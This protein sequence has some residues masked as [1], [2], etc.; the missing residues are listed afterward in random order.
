M[1]DSDLQKGLKVAKQ[2]ITDYNSPAAKIVEALEIIEPIRVSNKFAAE[3]F[4]LASK[5]PNTPI[6]TIV[7][8][9]QSDREIILLDRN[10]AIDLLLAEAPDLPLKIINY[11][12]RNLNDYFNKKYLRGKRTL[13]DWFLK[14]LIGLPKA[15]EKI[16]LLPSTTTN[17]LEIIYDR[18]KNS[19]NLKLIH[20][21]CNN[22]NA[23]PKILS[24]ILDR[25]QIQSCQSFKAIANHPN[26]PQE[27][28]TKLCDDW[29]LEVVTAA[30]SNPNLPLTTLHQKA[31]FSH[32]SIAA[33][34]R[35]L[36]FNQKLTKATK[37]KSYLLK[38]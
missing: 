17:W 13:P 24:D 36:L 26:T 14:P 8:I 1:L 34:A 6:D 25:P 28:L 20:Y 32:P 10:P 35:S 18:Y 23:S 15:A 37:L 31:R 3:I 27:I 12:E 2:I 38:D 7:K 4:S 29:E 5:N 22:P 11:G 19:R 21:I 33:I 16:A 9:A 30:I